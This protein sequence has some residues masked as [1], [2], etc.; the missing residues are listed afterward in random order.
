[1]GITITVKDNS[2]EFIEYLNSKKPVILETIGL[3]ASGHASALAPVD[4]GRLRGSIDYTVSEDTAY[5]GTNVEYAIYQ[6]MGTRY[7]AAQPFLKPAIEGNA[8]QYKSIIEAML[9]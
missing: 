1:M 2:Q 6:E 9:K 3:L 4:T 5:V 8:S 7:M